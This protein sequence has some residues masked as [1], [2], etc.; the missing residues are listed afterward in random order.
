M[1]P[2]LSG[3]VITVIDQAT[4]ML[5]TRHFHLHE[6][7]PV[8]PGLF[9]LRYIQNT[10][11]AWGIFAGGHNW[12]AVLSVVV[13]V[14][15][16]VF[17]RHL[18]TDRWLDRLVFGLIIGGISGNFIDRVKLHYVIDFFDFHWRG[19]HF[20]AFNVADSAICCGVAL[21]MLSQL[22]LARRQEEPVESGAAR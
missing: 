16:V 18:F 13:L 8:I 3:I 22:L 20:P 7:V 19:H 9:D 1:L 5:V 15:L 11:A 4:K 17:Q 14:A 21:Y 2:L 10:G 6:S 12:L